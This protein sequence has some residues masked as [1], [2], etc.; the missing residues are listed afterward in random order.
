MSCSET[1]LGNAVVIK[2]S[3]R[4]D[5]TTA[6]SFKD[7]ILAAL[8]A[9]KASLIIDLSGVEYISSAGLRSLMTGFKASKG[10]N[11][12]FAVAALQPLVLEI[13]TI[14]RFN[15]V[16]PVFETLRKAVESL[17]PDALPAFDAS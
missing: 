12:A 5:L 1:N 4:I 3:G 17:D 15:S 9:A 11:K 13:F 10:Q 6:D 16:F 2:A 14:S 7:S 8:A